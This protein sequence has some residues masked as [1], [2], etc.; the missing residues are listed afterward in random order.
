MLRHRLQALCLGI[1][2]EARINLTSG[3]RL[4]SLMT[5]PQ[6][7]LDSLYG[8]DIDTS[9]FSSRVIWSYCHRYAHDK[10]TLILE[11]VTSTLLSNMIRKRPNQE[12][13][14]GPGVMVTG[15]K[16]RGEERKGPSLSKAWY[17]CHREGHWKNDCKYQQEWLKKKGQ[18]AE[19]NVASDV[20][21]TEILMASY[22]DNTSQGK[23]GY[24]IQVERFMYIP[25]KVVQ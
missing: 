19:A 16:G 12:E 4:C 17:F 22:K 9:Q 23:T 24:L 13:Q 2:R 20:E 7:F 3:Y 10:E 25:K 11:E 6:W 14:I 1:T 15:G 8:S 18:A 5:C 21:D